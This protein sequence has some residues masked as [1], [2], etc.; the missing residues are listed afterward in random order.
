MKVL[1]VASNSQ[2]NDPLASL[3]LIKEMTELQKRFLSMGYTD[4]AFLPDLSLEDLPNAVR[5]R[6][7]DV[8]HLAAHGNNQFLSF[9]NT[10]GRAFRIDADMLRALLQNQPPK[11]VYLNSC[12]SH[13]IAEAL[14]A[15]GAAR[16]A[17]GTSATIS[18]QAARA[19]AVTF[20]E[21]I[22]AGRSVKVA[23]EQCDQMLRAMNDG[24]VRAQVFAAPTVTLASEILRPV[25]RLVASFK[26]ANPRRSANGQYTLTLGVRGCPV[27]TTQVT[28]VSDNVAITARAS[29]AAGQLWATQH[30]WVADADHR[31]LALGL[32]DPEGS[33]LVSGML[34][35]ALESHYGSQDSAMPAKVRQA[36]ARLREQCM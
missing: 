29:P 21:N 8:L 31:L 36:I 12:D 18:N 2:E 26:G 28:F 4:F 6:R 14:V 5:D 7:P 15:T 30:L 22:M 10:T 17:I 34:C 19:A 20:Y 11:L 25:V 16:V 27:G 13:A 24:T 3:N 35:E 1:F 32:K 23:F 33:F 9:T